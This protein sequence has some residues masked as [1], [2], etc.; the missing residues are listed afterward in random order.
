M[1]KF[2]FTFCLLFLGL[3][4]MGQAPDRTR[5][6]TNQKDK[7]WHELELNTVFLLQEVFGAREAGDLQEAYLVGF[8]TGKGNIGWRFGL[9]AS[10]DL[11]QEKESLVDI[12]D[13]TAY[14]L[15]ARLGI[16]WRKQLLERWQLISGIDGVVVSNFKKDVTTSSFDRISTED[17]ELAIGG[18]PLVGLRFWLNEK[19]SLATETGFQ[20]FY[21]RKVAS[22]D[23]QNLPDFDSKLVTFEYPFRFSP[24]VNLYLIIRF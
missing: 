2:G 19:I 3:L 21:V 14:T 6:S 4:L 13:Q 16:E 5:R 11:K 9:G 10:F 20:A 15:R 12:R 24:P 1:K 17:E 18:G 8:K 22:V 7:R 23:S